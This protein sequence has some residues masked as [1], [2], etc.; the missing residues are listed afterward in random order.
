MLRLVEEKPEPWTARLASWVDTAVA[1]FWPQAGV[2]RAEARSSLGRNSFHSASTTRPATKGWAT[3]GLSA[4]EDNAEVPTIRARSRSASRNIPLAQAGVSRMVTNVIGAFGLRPQSKVKRHLLGWSRKKARTWQ[5]DAEA[6]FHE[7]ANSRECDVERTLNFWEM[8]ALAFRSALDSG[9]VFGHKRFFSRPGSDFVFKLLV[10][11]ADRCDNPNHMTDTETLMQ[12]VEKD[13]NGAPTAYHFSKVHPGDF[14]ALRGQEEFVRVPAFGPNSGTPMVMHVYAKLRPG[15]TRGIPFMA[16]VLEILKQLGVYGDNVLMDAAVSSLFTAFI[17]TQ[18]RQPLKNPSVAPKPGQTANEQGF[19]QAAIVNLK[20]GETVTFADPKRDPQIGPFFEVWIEHLAAA[21]DMP[22]SVLRLRFQNSYTAGRAELLQA[23]KTF[24][25][26]REWMAAGWCQP[27]YD[28]VIAEAIAAG[29]LEGHP[30]FFTDNSIR[31]AMLATVWDGD[32]FGL[33]D[34]KR[35]AEGKEVLIRAGLTNRHIEARKTSGQDW[36]EVHDG[37][38]EEEEKRR[39]DGLSPELSTPSTEDDDEPDPDDDEP[40][41][42]DDTEEEDDDDTDTE[43]E[44]Q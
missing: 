20:H 44:D 26:R 8:Q 40:D 29:K 34:P 15:Q 2:E 1:T 3:F 9:D 28:E 30:D 14:R 18:D 22:S 39:E 38:A 33:L 27:S 5:R 19:G 6:V 25:K 32:A 31:C 42:E 21:L 13:E 17:T 11:E 37:L 23:V 7:W 10:I 35:E 36:E 16:G 43:E 24:M 41:T 12:G 4:D